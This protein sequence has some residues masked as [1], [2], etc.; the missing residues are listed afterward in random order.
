MSW[1]IRWYMDG[2]ETKWPQTLDARYAYQEGQWVIKDLVRNVGDRTL[3]VSDCFP[4][5]SISRPR[6]GCRCLVSTD[7]IKLHE[8][9]LRNGDFIQQTI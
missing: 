5:F 9:D 4:L 6:C 2:V 3:P 7:K 8:K 1:D